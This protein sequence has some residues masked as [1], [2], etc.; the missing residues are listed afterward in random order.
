MA[1]PRLSLPDSPQ[2]PLPRLAIGLAIVRAGSCA[3]CLR[4]C[5]L[6]LSQDISDLRA[7]RPHL[8]QLLLREGR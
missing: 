7:I 6:E 3:P 4:R 8:T 2:S 1:Q 5:L